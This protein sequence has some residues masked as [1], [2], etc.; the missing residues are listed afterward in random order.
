MTTLT[1]LTDPDKELREKSEDVEIGEIVTDAFQMMIDNL[2]ET[3]EFANGIGIAAPQIGVHKR[4]FIGVLNNEP[5]AFINPAITHTSL[6]KVNSEEGCL[7][8]PGTWGIVRRHKKITVEYTDRT[9]K[10]RKE[11]L[12]GLEGI[13]VQHENDHLDG[14]LFIDKVTKLTTTPSAL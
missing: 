6:L 12:H 5:H 13:V 7:S 2:I 8:I 1:I 9:G 4:V 10:I 14:V 11:K 3:M